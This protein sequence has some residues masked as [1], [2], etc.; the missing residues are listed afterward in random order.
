MVAYSIK[1]FKPKLF[2]NVILLVFYSMN[3]VFF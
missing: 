3:L 1:M 2:F